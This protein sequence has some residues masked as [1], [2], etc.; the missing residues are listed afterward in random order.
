MPMPS[1]GH[2]LD[3]LVGP[4]QVWV[5]T[6]TDYAHVVAEEL[7]ELPPENILGEPEG[8]DSLNAIAWTAAVLAA[9]DP[10]AVM[11]VVASTVAIVWNVTFNSLFEKWES[12]QTVKGRSIGRRI[13]HAPGFRPPHASIRARTADR[14]Y[15]QN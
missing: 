13:A 11:A 7:P 6:G 2:R 5:C 4:E 9:S 3:G 12:L 14:A 1:F 8:R 10:D 15:S